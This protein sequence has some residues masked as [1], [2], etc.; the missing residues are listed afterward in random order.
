MTDGHYHKGAVIL[1]TD[2]SY[3]DYCVQDLLVVINEFNLPERIT[4]WRN[5]EKRYSSGR[6]FCTYLVAKE[7]AI[8][9]DYT[10]ICLEDHLRKWSLSDI[11]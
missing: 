5:A 1:V 11:V 10:E 7:F 9:V 4:E 6:D 2:G 8:P 3:S